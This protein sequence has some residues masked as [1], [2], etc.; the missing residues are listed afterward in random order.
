M[1]R[2]REDSEHL[3]AEGETRRRIAHAIG[4]PEVE[5]FCSKVTDD[6]AGVNDKEPCDDVRVGHAGP[7]G[8]EKGVHRRD[9]DD[10][11]KQKLPGGFD[12]LEGYLGRQVE[13]DG[14]DERKDGNMDIGEVWL[15][16]SILTLWGRVARVKWSSSR[17]FVS[18][19]STRPS[20]K[21]TSMWA[22]SQN[23]LFT[24]TPHRQRVTRLRAS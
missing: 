12:L 21:S 5:E 23:G 7:Q 14:G 20:W 16:F 22:R 2:P 13:V 3:K 19:D 17:Y 15:Q 11:C 1:A 4:G 24:E 18:S 8:G 9:D 6:P 10:Y